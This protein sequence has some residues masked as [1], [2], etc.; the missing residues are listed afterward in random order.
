MNSFLI[1]TK[2]ELKEQLR[3]YKAFVLMIT[4]LFFG[5]T[6]PVFAKLMPEILNYFQTMDST[7]QISMKAP[8]FTDAYAQFYKNIGQMG[9]LIVILIFCSVVS[10][11]KLKGTG[12]IMLT[13]NLS[14]PTFILSKFTAMSILWTVCYAVSAATAVFYTVYL[15]PE[16]SLN[17]VFLSMLCLWLFVELILAITVLASTL[18]KN[19]FIGALCAFGGWGVLMIS[20]SI[21]KIKEITPTLLSGSSIS[22]IG[23]GASFS[24]FQSAIIASIVLIVL[25][26]TSACV[27]LKKQEL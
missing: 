24:D 19:F 1:F 12:I 18:S 22:L 9:I 4:M 7:I 6:S 27:I 14:R 25:A 8:A 20:A 3:T 16:G 13:K 15:F 11:E 21:P 10:Q 5:I 26:I 17:G 23:G 2:K